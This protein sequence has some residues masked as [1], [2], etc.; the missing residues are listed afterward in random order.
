[1]HNRFD[2]YWK[3]LSR[4]FRWLLISLFALGL[5]FRFANLGD[6]AYWHDETYTLLRSSGYT[7]SEVTHQSFDGRIIDRDELL[8]YQRIN[9]DKTFLNSLQ[10]I[11]IDEPHRAPLYYAFVRLWM[12]WFGSDVAATRLLSVLIS[13]IAFPLLYWLC[14]ELFDQINVGWIAIALFAVSPFQ[15]HYAQEVREY[16]LWTVTIL[17]MS[18]ALLRAIRVH[19][20]FAW[21]FYSVTVAASLYTF[22]LS[23]IVVLGQI[24]YVV[25]DEKL[26][27]NR[28]TIAFSKAVLLGW[29]AYLPWLSFA[30]LNFEQVEKS[31]AW[32]FQPT[33][34]R[35][36]LQH[37]LTN[38]Q[39]AFFRD[40]LAGSFRLGVAGAIVLLV[41]VALRSLWKFPQE[42]PVLDRRLVLGTTP[43]ETQRS[44]S[45][46][47]AVLVIPLFLS[48]AIPDVILGGVRSS[49][50]RYFVP[51]YLGIQIAVAGWLAKQSLQRFN[52]RW[53]LIMATLFLAGVLSCKSQASADRKSDNQAIAQIIN[54]VPNAIVVSNE[55]NYAG[56]GTIGDVL[57]LSHL[58]KSNVRFQLVIAP[59]LPTLPKHANVFVYKPLASIKQRLEAQYTLQP[60]YENQLFRIMNPNS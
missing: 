30:F 23:A 60:I 57:A 39:F 11:V 33:A 4:P 5:F 1:M 53:K 2:R 26:R 44:A 40:S 3:P 21:I 56:G 54:Q 52:V 22:I 7:I 41:G 24:V 51:G 17:L 27:W 58:V 32:M 19:T 43:K 15:V 55:A 29:I 20:R 46:F 35:I 59:N 6:R 49:N 42:S 12:Q 25:A 38:F 28:K 10:S 8:N 18:A 9:T 31:S 13:L 50:C 36:L 37:W 47:I 14:L 16:A 48:L 45:L 34:H